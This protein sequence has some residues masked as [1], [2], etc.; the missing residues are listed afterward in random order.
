MSLRKVTVVRS[1]WL[2]FAEIMVAVEA[3]VY[4]SSICEYGVS[5]DLRFPNA[6]M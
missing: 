4:W 2:T 3:G 5:F 1:A 6:W